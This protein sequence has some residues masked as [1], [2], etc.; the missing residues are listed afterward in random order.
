MDVY[1]TEEEQIDAIKGWWKKNGMSVALAALLAVG[2]YAGWNW[3]RHYQVEQSL[4]ASELY[5][6]MMQSLQQTSAEGL[7][8]SDAA[9]RV[10]SAGEELVGKHGGSVYAHFAALM[11]AAGAVEQDDLPGAEK[12]LRQAL[13]QEPDA[14]LQALATD[15]LARV[16]SAQGRHDEALKL[17]D[18][19]A[20]AVLAAARDE[21]RGDILFAQ[22]KRA[23]AKAAWQKARAAVTAED[24]ARGVLDM[25]IDY[26]AAE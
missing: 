18:A 21:V 24:P 11:L 5:Q 23:D 13:E 16:I 25:K 2:V 9:Q 26:V 1:R 7:V 4:A 17:L 22:G 20:P 14:A 10:V 6:S 12:Y 8:G 3:Y 15:R 19:K